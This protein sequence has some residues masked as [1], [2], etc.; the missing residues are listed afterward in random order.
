MSELPQ[1]WAP[2]TLGQLAGGGQYGWTTK[3][4]DSGTTKFLRT[5]DITKGSIIWD[6]VPYC[7]ETPSADDKYRLHSGDILISRAGSVGFSVL[8][9]TI[10]YPT[11]FASY[12]IRFLPDSEQVVPQYLAHFLRSPSYWNQI[13]GVSAGIA[14]S[15]V[16]ATK[17]A[18]VAV[19]LAPIN[20]QKRIADKLD[21][22]LARVD[23]CRERLDHM[24]A[25]LK[26]FRQAV[27]AAATS[28]TLTEEWRN[29][30][31]LPDSWPEVSLRDVA[32]DFSYG[33]AA[34]SAK[35]GTV[36]V[37]RM[38][39][40]QDGLL[41][42]TDLVFTSDAAEISKYSLAPG[43][44]LFNRTN[45][46]ELVGKTAIYRG[47]R[48]AVYAGYLIRVRCTNRL[49]PDYLNYC[50]NSPAGRD[51]RWRVKSDGVSQSNINAKKLAAFTFVLPTVE[52]QH[53]IVR[54]VEALFT[55][56]D[57]LEARNA[58]ARAQVDRLTPAL[59]AKA[60]RG[61][62][63]EQDPN[64]EPASELL[65]RLQAARAEE[66]AK[67]RKHKTLRR[68]KVKTTITEEAVKA[69]IARLPTPSFSF[70]DLRSQVSGDY[71]TLKDVI[72]NLLTD[73]TSGITQVFDVQM[74]EMRFQRTRPRNCSGCILSRRRPVA[75]CSMAWTF[76]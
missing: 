76:G 30:K 2:A 44:V 31:Q 62:L 17:L 70:D 52:E 8:L 29:K 11:V 57:R 74:S 68:A 21:A 72:F 60:F 51:Y 48:P 36:P 19:P 16:N 63:V 65:A 1:G 41:D 13:A 24:P 32:H 20:E 39:N 27:L 34:K 18:E 54:R 4:T 10:P 5:T 66:V 9:E 69:I 46:P 49:L 64:D 37:L 45:S 47:E 42:W 55:Y 28:G 35:L 50:L 40:I 33:S 75:V 38:G 61:E 15:N 22:V 3:A 53:E 7:H 26:R 43:D 71:E 59:L 12:L 56:A 6:R 73:P 25:I 23:A 14:L 67:P 58:T